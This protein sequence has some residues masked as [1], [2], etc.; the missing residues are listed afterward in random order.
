MARTAKNV[1]METGVAIILLSQLNRSA[2][3]PSIRM[4]RGSGQ[5]EESADNVVLIDRP[6]AYPEMKNQKYEGEFKDS[7]IEGTAKLI[8]AKGRG[9]GTCCNLVAFSAKET[10]F[11]DFKKPESVGNYE[12]QDAALPF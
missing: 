2:A 9:V 12:E 5:I 8:L 4:L 10:R 7:P 3:H 11:A 6:E 1:A